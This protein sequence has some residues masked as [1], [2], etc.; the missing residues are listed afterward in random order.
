MGELVRTPF[1]FAV[2]LTE[3]SCDFEQVLNESLSCEEDSETQLA[4]LEAFLI[5]IGF[6]HGLS[7]LHARPIDPFVQFG[8]KSVNQF[9]NVIEAPQTYHTEFEGDAHVV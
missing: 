3:G 6:G 9:V 7:D 4:E 8:I 5:R 1:L 2:L